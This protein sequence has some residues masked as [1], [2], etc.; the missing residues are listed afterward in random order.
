LPNQRRDRNDAMPLIPT[1]AGLGPRRAIIA[2]A[3]VL[4]WLTP[5]MAADHAVAIM[6]HRFGED[7][8]PSTSIKLQQFEAHLQELS[9][10]GYTVL[11]LS[12]VMARIRARAPLPD[13]AV[14]I[15]LDDAF[16]SVYTEAWPRLRRAGFP[17][18]LFVAT[19]TLDA[20]GPD[21]M[22][23]DQVRELKAAG[24]EIAAHTR[25]HRH[26]AAA[27]DEENIAEIAHANKRLETELG[28]KP[29]FFAY[30]YGEWSA[31]VRQL[32]IKAG[33]EAAF[34]QHSGV[35][36]PEHD[37]F[38]LPRFAFS[39]SYGD[40]E[41]F[42]R[43][44]S[45]LPLPISDLTPADPM[46]TRNPPEIGFTLS[47]T[48]PGSD[49][50]ACF[51]SNEPGKAR[52]ERLG[53]RRVEVRVEKPFPPGRGRVNCTAPAADGRWRWFSLQFYIPG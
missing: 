12:D 42:R 3:A 52:L 7:R 51:A 1:A 46:L 39:D 8:Y 40:M 29:R 2:L 19:E 43:A 4:A 28:E 11:P 47:Q 33:Y 15:T 31:K 23:W 14:V 16:R 36:Y 27:S 35:I 38:S 48:P 6:Y 5:A 45:A 32:V 50:L 49:R 41:R 13:R 24:A 17:F 44:V 22:T 30:P 53:A 21:Y 37:P 18:A 26:M 10:G 34:G 9:T 20:K 25:R